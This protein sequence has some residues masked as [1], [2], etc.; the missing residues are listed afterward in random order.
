[1]FIVLKSLSLSVGFVAGL[2]C[3]QGV[4][5][6]SQQ[7]SAQGSPQVQRDATPPVPLRDLQAM[8]E[9]HKARVQNRISAAVERVQTACQD[10]LRNFC[11]TVT[12]GEGRLLLCMQAHEDKLSKQCGFALFDASRNIQQVA[13]R[14]ERVAQACWSDIQT[15]CADGGSIAKCI[16]EKRASLSPSCQAVAAALQPAMPRQ[17]T[18]TGLALYSS[19]GVRVG[20]VMGVKAGLDGRPQVIQAE[21]GSLLGLGTTT[22]LIT[23]DEIER[24]A[25][26]ANGVQLRMSADQIREALQAQR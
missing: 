14:V 20:E 23:P 9:A 16:A 19:D 11:S 17:P 10:E 13:S 3:F 2:A 15:H 5:A 25:D 12:P 4:L 1:M 6:Q 26:G 18:L 22:V 24:R 21:I 7:D 8:I